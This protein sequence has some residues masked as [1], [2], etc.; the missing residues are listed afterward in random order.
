M[1]RNYF[2]EEAIEH[3]LS[4]LIIKPNVYVT[5]LLVGQ[6]SLQRDFVVLA[7]QTP[8][9]EDQNDASQIKN[10]QKLDSIDEEWVTEH[11]RQVSRMLPGGLFVLGVFLITSP[12]FGKEA[13]N[14]LRK[15]I[16]SIEKS[17]MKTRLWSPTEDDVADRVA[18]HFC[19]A[20]KKII[21][22]TYDVRDAKSSA[23]PADW[24]YQGGVSSSWLSLECSIQVDIL[25]PLPAASVSNDLQ[26]NIRDGLINWASQIEKCIFLFN[27]QIKEDECEVLQGPPLSSDDR[28]TATVQ[29]CRGSAHLKGVVKCRACIHSNKPKVKDA[30][31]AMKRDILNTV[32]DRCEALF[33]D[34]VLEGTIDQT[35]FANK[36]HTLPLRVFAPI[37]GSTVRLCDYMFR[38]E[39]VGDIQERFLEMLDLDLEEKDFVV[40][41]V[42]DKDMATSDMSQ[43]LGMDKINREHTQDLNKSTVV[44]KIWQNMGAVLAAACALLATIV[45][46]QYYMD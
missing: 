17:V 31:Q 23:K 5:G 24:K 46:L 35:A 34:L 12:E 26:K 41:E 37:A 13:Q 8:S 30:V 2:V 6:F 32:S 36:T 14:V 3:Y 43:A 19:S 10:K 29:V 25:I 40:A 9:K 15:L 45:S 38:D 33:E 22:R 27:G 16:F 18:L 4:S 1:G 11:A 44:F 28:C 39:T 42:I 21:C 20:T 7:V